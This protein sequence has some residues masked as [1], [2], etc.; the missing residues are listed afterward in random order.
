MSGNRADSVASSKEVN[1]DANSNHPLANYL[2]IKQRLNR[3]KRVFDDDK[4]ATLDEETENRTSLV[5]KLLGK[6]KESLDI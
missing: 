3:K 4:I 5:A 1:I 2:K 6:S